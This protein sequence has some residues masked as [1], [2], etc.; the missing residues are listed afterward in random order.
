MLH[1]GGAFQSLHPSTPL[2]KYQNLNVI[3][4]PFFFLYSAPGKEV[5]RL[6]SLPLSAFSYISLAGQF[7]AL[8]YAAAVGKVQQ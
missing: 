8:G 1:N 5:L 3:C 2:F 6:S 7:V 4:V